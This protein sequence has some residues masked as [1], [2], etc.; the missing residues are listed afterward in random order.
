VQLGVPTDVDDTQLKKA[1][2]KAAMLVSWVLG[3]VRL[4]FK[5]TLAI[6]IIQTRTNHPR[7]RRSS[8]ISGRFVDFRVSRIWSVLAK[9]TQRFLDVIAKPIRSFQIL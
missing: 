8:R 9:L 5:S 1:Y 4:M 3:I 7:Q 6:S 2:R